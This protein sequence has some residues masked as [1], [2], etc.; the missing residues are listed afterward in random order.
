VTDFQVRSWIALDDEDLVN[1]EEGRKEKKAEKFAV[2]TESSIGLTLQD[3]AKGLKLL[4]D[5]IRQFYH[6]T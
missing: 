1:V 2:K 3:V 4:E 5:Q 6:L